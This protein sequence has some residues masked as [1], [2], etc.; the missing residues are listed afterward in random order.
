MKLRGIC[1]F[2]SM[3]L[4]FSITT[5]A[6]QAHDLTYK[7]EKGKTYFFK[8][9]YEMDMTQ[10]MMGQD[11]SIKMDTKMKYRF[12]VAE[13]NSDK[14]EIISS[15]DSME[16]K[17]DSPL[18]TAESLDEA[19][20]L[21]IGKKSKL[22]YDKAGKLIQKI[23]IDKLVSN[24]NFSV[25]SSTEGLFR[26]SNKPVKIGESWQNVDSSKTKLGEKGELL[27]IIITDLVLEGAENYNGAECLKISFKQKATITGAISAEGNTV[28]MEGTI[29][30]NGT[31]LFNEKTGMLL[32]SKQDMESNMTISM[33]EQNMT[34]PIIQKM[35]MTM[36]LDK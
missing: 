8:M 17:S 16:S 14:I 7:F 2:I 20:K 34:I 9:V 25:S 32:F 35:K 13:S 33:P 21:I 36:F 15:V 28:G 12:E 19:S 30:G 22:I 23:E 3:F 18:V 1:I 27:S 10:S 6:Q 4:L 31:I 5:H 29:N 24:M 26:L 11:M